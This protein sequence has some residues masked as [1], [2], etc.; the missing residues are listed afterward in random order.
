VNFP[1]YS[2]VLNR[3]VNG[4]RLQHPTTGEIYGGTDWSSPDKCAEMGL[5]SL[6]IEQ[7]ATG[8]A[9]DWEIVDD[10]ENQGCKLKRPTTT[11]RTETVTDEGFEATGWETVVDDTE[12]C[13][14]VKRPIGTALISGYVDRLKAAKIAAIDARTA[15]AVTAGF[16][17]DGHQFSM[18]AAAQANWQLLFLGVL[19]GKINDSNIAYIGAATK[20]EEAY[21][22]GTML[23]L[24]AFLTAYTSY[25]MDPTKPLATGRALKAAV[26]AAEAIADVHAIVDIRNS[27]QDI[28]KATTV[29]TAVGVTLSVTGA[30]TYSVVSQ[31]A[32][33]ELSGTAPDLTYTP[34]QDYTGSDSFT[35]KANNGLVD[36]NIATVTV[37]IAE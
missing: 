2:T 34:S 10:P 4:G 17:H 8:E 12:A 13:D 35:Y 26:A 23:N 6:R 25:L 37:T 27:A 20:T 5:V 21:V 15:A 29:N 24:G 1:A 14:F 28:S 9:I 32:H 33:G 30:L 36:S 7:P 11:L 18:S 16:T 19:S 31:P 3:V 22:F